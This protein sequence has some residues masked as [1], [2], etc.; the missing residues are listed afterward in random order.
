MAVN[1]FDKQNTQ[2]N[3][4]GQLQLDAA[5]T[6][7]QSALLN[8]G[9]SITDKALSI[10]DSSNTT[11]ESAN[12]AT[13]GTSVAQFALSVAQFSMNSNTGMLAGLAGA[14]TGGQISTFKF[15]GAIPRFKLGGNTINN[16]G[17]IKGAGSG[18]SDSI[19]SYM[20]DQNK[21][22]AVSNGEFIMN[23]KATSKYRA[24][25]EAMNLDKFKDGGMISPEP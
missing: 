24:I 12:V 2:D 16:G 15:G 4:A 7:S 10:T 21:F 13:F 18:T 1:Y 9:I 3:K 11:L 17:K 23:A 5:K 19:L 22:I 14:K 6:Q 20:A 25:L 8:Q